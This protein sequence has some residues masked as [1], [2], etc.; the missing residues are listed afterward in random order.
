MECFIGIDIANNQHDYSGIVIFD[1]KKTILHHEVLRPCDMAAKA[2]RFAELI[3]NY[4]AT[5]IYEVSQKMFAD[6]VTIEANKIR[7]V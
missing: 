6:M 3:D 5:P 4:C 2:K 1:G 7:R